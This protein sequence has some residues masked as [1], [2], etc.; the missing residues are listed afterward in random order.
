ME[1]C[2]ETDE[3][4]TSL[5]SKVHSQGIKILHNKREGGREGGR[6]LHLPVADGETPVAPRQ[7]GV[8]TD[9]GGGGQLNDEV[10]QGEWS[11]QACHFTVLTFGL[12][13]QKKKKKK[14]S[15]KDHKI[16]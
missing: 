5:L 4:D 14:K 13:L 15:G 8:G 3:R 6:E 9:W 7:E 1:V 10:L 12:V 2:H 11:S 16:R